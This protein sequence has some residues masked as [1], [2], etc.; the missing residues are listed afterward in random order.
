MENQNNIEFGGQAKQGD[1]NESDKTGSAL[2]E[3][4]RKERKDWLIEWVRFKG[5]RTRAA[6]LILLIALVFTAT[7]SLVY[8]CWFKW[9]SPLWNWGFNPT[10]WRGIISVLGTLYLILGPFFPYMLTSDKISGI[11][12]LYAEDAEKDFKARMLEVEKK[13]A[14]YEDILNEKDT[15]GLIPLVTY[16]RIELEQYYR[17]GLSQTQGSYKFSI[18]AMWI[19]FIIISFGIIS[20]IVPSSFINKELVGGNFQILTISSGIISEVIS[21]LFLW[22]YKSS[23]NQLTYFYNRQIFVHNALLAFKISNTMK[24]SDSSKQIII[25]KILEFGFDSRIKKIITPAVK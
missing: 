24:E 22:I 3:H 17:I 12:R 1:I 18:I 21:A 10:T 2:S 11:I 25:K 4:T 15:E 8:F 6:L 7:T 19:G 9:L 13:Q 20:Y 16:S 14:T 23:I 5:K